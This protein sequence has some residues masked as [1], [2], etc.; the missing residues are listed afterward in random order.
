MKVCTSTG[1]IH[2]QMSQSVITM[3]NSLAEYKDNV[4]T[5]TGDA[6]NAA[7]STCKF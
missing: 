1:S 4:G 7:Q 6:Q 3:Q 5:Y 2:D